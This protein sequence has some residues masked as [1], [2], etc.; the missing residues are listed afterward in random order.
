MEQRETPGGTP[1]PAVI[2]ALGAVAAVTLLLMLV[3]AAGRE[4]WLDEYYTALLANMDM[5]DM[6]RYLRGDVHPPV[7]YLIINLWRRVFGDSEIALRAFSIIGHLL[8]GLT[9]L[10]VAR[11]IFERWS[12]AAVGAALF[13]LSPGLQFHGAEA[14]MY[15]L[16][17][18]L[19]T[20]AVGL[21][22]RQCEGRGTDREALLLGGV[23]ALAFYTHYISLFMVGALFL[24]WLIVQVRKRARWQPLLTSGITFGLLT[25]PWVPIL[26]QQMRLK[27]A[28]R[29]ASE[30]SWTDPA[31]L[32]YGARAEATIDVPNPLVEFV[33]NNA[34]LTGVYPADNPALLLLGAVP[35]AVVLGLAVWR[36]LSGALP[37]I[38]V[39]IA[40]LTNLA[41]CLA[42]GIL[43]RRYQLNIAPLLVL[44][45]CLGLTVA[46]ERSRHRLYPVLAGLILLLTL[47]GA[48]RVAAATSDEPRFTPHIETIRS[49]YRPGDLVVF[50]A[51]YGQTIFDYRARRLGFDPERRGFPETLYDWWE[52]QPHKGWGGPVILESNLVEFVDHVE[53][54]SVESVWLVEFEARY[55]DPLGRLRSAF[56]ERGW[57]VEPCKGLPPSPYELFLITRRSGTSACPRGDS[58]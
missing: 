15:S 26:L 13:L 49:G 3:R 58:P 14:R 16:S 20:A 28:L 4:F 46:Y 19:T 11:V 2:V 41:G 52:R 43:Q 34:S 51:L 25:A 45:V 18:L 38:L 40:V 29:A 32:A 50:N 22:W 6:F 55:Y 47:A 8:G 39:A 35:F 24:F 5:P 36:T 44:F 12:I 30:A 42:L 56:E 17:V 37:G 27:N 53:Q 9:F 21:V 48:V 57:S 1:G 54:D 7:Y 10:F 23:C 33:L 31:S